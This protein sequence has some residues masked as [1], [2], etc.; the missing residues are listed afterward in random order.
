MSIDVENEIFHAVEEL[1]R[2]ARRLCGMDSDY[3]SREDVL[4]REVGGIEQLSERIR[5]GYCWFVCKLCEGTGRQKW[6]RRD[7]PHFGTGPC[8]RCNGTGVVNGLDV[9]PNAPCPCHE[10]NGGPPCTPGH[11]CGYALA[12]DAKP[13]D[14]KRL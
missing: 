6:D 9:E 5:L 4:L 13:K 1:L 3:L 12:K 11:P 2:S 8:W 7:K 10:P 14:W